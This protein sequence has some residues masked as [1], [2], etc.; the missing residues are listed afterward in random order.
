MLKHAAG[1]GVQVALDL[2]PGARSCLVDQ[3]QLD[4]AVMNL[5]VNAAQA[6][7]EGGKILIS[8][9]DRIVPSGGGSAARKLV[10]V[11]VK[12]TGSGIAP[13][14]LQRIF[15]P[16]FTTQQDSGTDRKRDV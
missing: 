15:E 5:V 7:P 11:R 4:A 16:F 1:Q 2:A 3:A 8:T 9:E 6:M 12:D 10:C 13:E 14:N